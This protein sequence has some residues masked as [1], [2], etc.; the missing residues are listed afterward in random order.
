MQTH[1]HSLKGV[2][3]EVSNMNP[4]YFFGGVDEFAP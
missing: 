3:D 1:F 4:D 2:L